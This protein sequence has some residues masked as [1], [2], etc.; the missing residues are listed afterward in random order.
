MDSRHKRATKALALTINAGPDPGH[1]E[2][3]F[4]PMNGARYD[5]AG[6]HGRT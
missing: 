2:V 3:P 5:R 1:F 6:A 4:A